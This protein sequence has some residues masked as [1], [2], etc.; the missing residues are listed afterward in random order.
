MIMILIKHIIETNI[1]YY[2]QAKFYIKAK[3]CVFQC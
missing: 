1:Y 2:M 3:L